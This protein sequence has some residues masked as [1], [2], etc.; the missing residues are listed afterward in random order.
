MRWTRRDF[1]RHSALGVLAGA[2][3]RALLASP[4]SPRSAVGTDPFRELRRNVGTFTGRGGTIGWLAN[5]DG[6][7]VVDSQFP[8]TAQVCLDG[9]A[10]RTTLPL[11]AL[12]NT[13]HHGDHTGGNAVFRDSARRIVAQQRAVEL[14]RDAARNAEAAAEP[15]YA[16]TVFSDEWTL[17]VGDE[18]VRATYYGAAHTGG[19]CTILFEQ[20]GV[21]HMGDLV[22]NRLFPFIDR[23]G[24]G[25]ARGWV[26][27]LEAVTAKHPAD[28]L[29]VFGHGHPDFGITGR[30]DDLLLQRD[31]LA[32][33]LDHAGQAIAAG[34]SRD[35]AAAVE[36]LPGFPDHIA[37]NT[38][39]TLE[40]AV[41]A[42]YDELREEPR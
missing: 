27:L 22:F 29:F 42:A 2:V 36:Q 28:T 31:F 26:R 38:W 19:D 9:L 8:D 34:R 21:V 13:H 14:Q 16:D 7:V 25:S 23:A 17:D 3:P 15:V 4:W 41:L 39:L 32:A 40:R 35:E 24:G 10:E 33:L 6:A 5:R 12:I 18:R 30:R 1:I 37:P 11:D 20:A